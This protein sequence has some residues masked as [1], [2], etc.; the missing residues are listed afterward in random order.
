V[1]TL[2]GLMFLE[3][4][5][6]IEKDEFV[7]QLGYCIN[8]LDDKIININENLNNPGKSGLVDND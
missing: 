2:K 8:D 4:D 1:A 6:L 5:N 7:E 3:K